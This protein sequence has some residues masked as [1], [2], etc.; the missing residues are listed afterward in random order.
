MSGNLLDYII[1]VPPFKDLPVESF[2][3]I[4]DSIQQ[5]DF[6]TGKI[7]FEAG[8]KGDSLYIIRE[9]S[10]Q[11]FVLDAESKEKIILSQLGP[12]D[13]FGEM[14]LLTGEPRSASIETRI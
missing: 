8:E 12:G 4:A 9:G 13:Y 5:I 10:V 14:A 3:S 7:I 2:Q 11:V 6:I 1:T